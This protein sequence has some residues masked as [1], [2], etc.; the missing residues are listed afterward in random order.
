MN[1]ALHR[2]NWAVI[3]EKLLPAIAYGDAA[4][5]P[6]EGQPPVGGIAELRP[7]HAN[8]IF[9]GPAGMWSDDTQ[10]SAA[11]M[12]AL[13]TAGGFDLD[14]IAHE[15][16]AQLAATPTVRRGG[17]IIVR[18]WG[19]STVTAV[20]RY[21]HGTRADQCGT[22]GGA[23]NGVLMKLAPLVYW[24]H[25]AAMSSDS[26][27]EQW[28]ALTQFTHGSD[29]ARICTRVHGDILMFILGGG[30]PEDLAD[31]ATESAIRHESALGAAESVSERLGVLAGLRRAGGE[32]RLRNLTTR[33]GAGGQLYGFYAP[34][35][36]VCVYGAFI[37]WAAKPELADTV[38]AAVSL[39]GDTD[40]VASIVAAMMVF[41][42]G[43]SLVLPA[44]YRRL[45]QIDELEFLS[46][47]FAAA[48]CGPA[49]CSGAGDR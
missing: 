39:G 46:E 13:I 37:L 48:A 6:F 2:A 42:H 31:V 16:V 20:A 38:Y 3:G 12:R 49:S 36:L 18:G 5:L 27:V 25:M 22:P 4:G 41:R 45:T 43:H 35:T 47:Q 33:I 10:L 21:H 26:V 34:E 17:T 29:A 40:T 14:A 32:A 30:Q 24:Q 8:P 28:D 11:V 9:A 15:H 19:N 44:D 23:G 1:T 7:D